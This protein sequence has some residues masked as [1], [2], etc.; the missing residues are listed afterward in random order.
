MKKYKSRAKANEIIAK[1]LVDIKEN[2]LKSDFGK[3][4]ELDDRFNPRIAL[5]FSAQYLLHCKSRVDTKTLFTEPLKGYAA[6]YK[7]FDFARL[8]ALNGYNK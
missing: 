5:D 8:L 3:L 7:G 2:T 4:A 6:K 1:K